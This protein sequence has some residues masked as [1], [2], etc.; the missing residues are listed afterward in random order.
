[1]G[2]LIGGLLARKHAVTLVGRGTHIQAIQQDGL[3]IRGRTELR[4]RPRAVQDIA[5]A[6][7]PDVVILTVKSYDTAAALEALRPLAAESVFLSLQNGLGNVEQLTLTAE[8]VLGGVTYHGVTRT[9]PGEIYHAGVGDTIF[10]PFQG[11]RLTEVETIATAFR[12]SG[13]EAT[14]TGNPGGALWNKAVVNACFN[15]LTGLLRAR[16]GALD[17]SAIL[18]KCCEM[19]IDEA[20]AVAQQRGVHLDRRFLLDRIGEVARATAQNR[21]SMLQDLEN[22]RRTEIDAINGAI[23]RM[24]EET[25]VECPANRLLAL[26]VKAAEEFPRPAA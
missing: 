21:S 24:G 3:I 8:R 5:E 25:G 6:D 10:G 23:V 4:I 9:G 7:P 18:L 2:S 22:G 17:Q 1:M 19:I 13:I 14:V 16:S 12:E 15:P 26:L 11:A 20:V